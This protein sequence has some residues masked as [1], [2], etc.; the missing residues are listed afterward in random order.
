MTDKSKNTGARAGPDQRLHEHIRLLSERLDKAVSDLPNYQLDENFN[1]RRYQPSLKELVAVEA[2]RSFH[3][4]LQ[5]ALSAFRAERHCRPGRG[6]AELLA[7]L[8]RPV[9]AGRHGLTVR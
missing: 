4:E 2:V 6:G 3:L 1:P 5:V 7:S 9:G 8:R